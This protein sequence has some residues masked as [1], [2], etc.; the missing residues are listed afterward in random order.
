MTYTSRTT[1]T[2]AAPTSTI[3]KTSTKAVTTTPSV[4]PATCASQVP[5]INLFT[6]EEQGCSTLV[7]ADR[8]LLCLLDDPQANFTFSGPPNKINSPFRRN[9]GSFLYTASECV[10]L[11]VPDSRSAYFVSLVL[12]ARS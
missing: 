9:A 4:K 6:F 2:T 5:Y 10:E 12:F 8:D 7:D 3:T 11:A 1:V